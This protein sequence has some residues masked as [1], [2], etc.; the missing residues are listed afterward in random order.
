M[1]VGSAGQRMPDSTQ[2]GLQSKGNVL[3]W[4]KRVQ[5]AIPSPW[6]KVLVLRVSLLSVC[7]QQR[8]AHIAS[9]ASSDI[10]SSHHNLQGCKARHPS[11]VPSPRVT[12]SHLGTRRLGNTGDAVWRATS[13]ANP[14]GP[15]AAGGSIQQRKG[16]SP[17]FSQLPCGPQPDPAGP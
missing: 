7:W 15:A 8:S 2:A 12:E 1:L 9:A 17:P 4:E 16:W 10:T 11:L 13:E 3:P 5:E 14:G 6:T